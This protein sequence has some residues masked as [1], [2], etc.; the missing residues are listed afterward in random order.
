MEFE[1]RLE[2]IETLI[3]K[4]APWVESGPDF[5]TLPNS[6]L[7]VD[8]ARCAPYPLIDLVQMSFVISVDHYIHA[9]ALMREFNSPSVSA[10]ATLLRAAMESAWV[11]LW[12]ITPDD[13]DQRV[14][15][16]L[17]WHLTDGLDLI[18]FALD[19]RQ[20]DAV[21]R[22]DLVARITGAATAGGI[23]PDRV[24]GRVVVTEALTDL[25]E[26]DGSAMS[27]RLW[28]WREASAFAH[29]R[30][31]VW[32]QATARTDVGM[33]DHGSTLWRYEPKPE[34][35]VVHLMAGIMAIAELAARWETLA[36]TP[37]SPR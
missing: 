16:A 19:D 2:Q 31:W 30:P 12:V 15:R 23:D 1:H 5:D 37:T 20:H 28:A 7:R 17:R 3:G 26:Q 27:S 22:A 35:D 33:L 9:H 32:Q 11:A 18:R 21:H 4:F 8:D 29:A 13:S 14:V 34:T 6:L 24:S 25:D 10:P 36:T